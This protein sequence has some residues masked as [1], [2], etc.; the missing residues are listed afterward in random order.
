MADFPNKQTRKLKKKAIALL[1]LKPCKDQINFLRKLTSHYDI[2][3]ICDQQI[4]DLDLPKISNIH[5]IH[6]SDTFVGNK[7]YKKSC[8][9]INKK[10]GAQGLITSWDKSIY[11]FCEVNTKYSH[12]WFIEDDVFIP[13]T[14]TLINID[15][16]YGNSYDLLVNAHY[17]SE[18][19]D[20][21]KW[22]VCKKW[23]KIK[24]ADYVLPLPWFRSMQCANRVS[25]QLLSTVKD[26]VKQHN[27]LLYHE[28]M[29]NTLSYINNLNVKVIDELKLIKFRNNNDTNFN[30]DE[31]IDF[32]ILYHPMKD[33]KL[34]KIYHEIIEKKD[35][36]ERSIQT[37]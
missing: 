32:N 34:Q 18:N 14:N 21:E 36:L 1:C 37:H 5:Y 23:D 27:T 33:M 11:Y 6:Y 22:G 7:G 4:S 24:K 8:L 26:F 15:K 29:F 16:K 3:F 19:G 20:L 17:K 9:I 2:Y 13:L 30:Y 28:Y 31:I 10:P 12:V 25:K 35:K